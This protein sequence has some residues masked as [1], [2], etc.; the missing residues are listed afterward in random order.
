MSLE[1]LAR[2]IIG[3]AYKT[4]SHHLIVKVNI[5]RHTLTQNGILTPMSTEDLFYGQLTKQRR[6]RQW[7]TI[8]HL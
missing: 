4:D 8:T 5:V 6:R 2:I 7:H 3:I 1:Y